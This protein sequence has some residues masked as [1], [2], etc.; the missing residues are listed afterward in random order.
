MIILSPGSYIYAQ[1][2]WIEIVT[3]TPELH[4]QVGALLNEFL[5]AGR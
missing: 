3:I 4:I 1:R 2:Q 5:G